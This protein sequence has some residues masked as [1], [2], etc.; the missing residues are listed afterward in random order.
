MTFVFFYKDFPT[1]SSLSFTTLIFRGLIF[2]RSQG[3]G[4]GYVV[5][6]FFGRNLLIY[7]LICLTNGR[8][9]M[10][11][12]GLLLILSSFFNYGVWSKRDH[13]KR[14]SKALALERRL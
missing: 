2:C 14:A 5:F 7:C 1:L 11:K 13:Q 9:Y 10:T 12:R 4:M 8:L 6:F 3:E